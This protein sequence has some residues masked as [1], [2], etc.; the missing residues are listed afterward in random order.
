MMAILIYS[1]EYLAALLALTGSC[2]CLHTIVLADSTLWA[3]IFVD[4]MTPVIA[5]IF[6]LSFLAFSCLPDPHL[7]YLIFYFS[8]YFSFQLFKRTQ[9]RFHSEANYG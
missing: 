4:V 1:E 3:D 5:R 7:R 6:K 2:S 9:I 8:L